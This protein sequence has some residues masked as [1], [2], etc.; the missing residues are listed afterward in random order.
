MS[1]TEL[2]IEGRERELAPGLVIKRILPHAVRRHVGPF[3]FL[4]HMG[5][6]DAGPR[7]IADVRPHPHIGL[8]TVTWLFSGVIMHRDSLGSV[9][10]IR[11]GELNWMNAGKAITHSERM[12]EDGG[13]VHLHGMQAWVALPKHLEESEPFFSHVGQGVLPVVHEP[14]ARLTVIAGTAFGATSPLETP[15]PLFYVEAKLDPGTVIEVPETYAERAAY[16]AEGCVTIDGAEYGVGQLPV[17]VPG[18]RV[19]LRA[20]TGATVMILGGEPLDGER[21]INWNFVSSDRDRIARARDDWQAG[22]FPQ[23]PGE[24]EFIPLPPA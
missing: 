1:V 9:Q 6:V 14:G 17:F 2:V 7:G 10:P 13:L 24:T 8:A 18:A 19:A 4:D 23:V 5:P 20:E 15:S 3:V 22:R 12:P 11:P 16:V 21:H